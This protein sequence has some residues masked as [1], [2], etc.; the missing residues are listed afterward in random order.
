I[1]SLSRKAVR[2][3]MGPKCSALQ[4]RTSRVE[5]SHAKLWFRLGMAEAA[6]RRQSDWFLRIAISKATR[7]CEEAA[8]LNEQGRPRFVRPLRS[9]RDIR[10]Y[11]ARNSTI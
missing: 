5:K 11:G 6:R 9:G 1:A 4:W 7:R 10:A 8:Q 2:I 3:P